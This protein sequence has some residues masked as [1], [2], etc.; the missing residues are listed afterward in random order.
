M[1]TLLLSS[2][3]SMQRRLA[4][5][6]VLLSVCAALP[7]LAQ[8]AVLEVIALKYRTAE[9]VI[10]VLRPLLDPRGSLSGMQNQLIIR[11]TPANL[12]ELKQVLA[13]LDAMP[14]R[15]LITV[16][17]DAVLDRDRTRAEVSGRV[18]A[19]D[20]TVAVPGSGR[21]GGGVVEVQRGDD[22][23][24][25]RIDST[26]SLDSDRNT[27]TLQVLE[28]NSAFI[29][30]GQSVPL[31]Q[32]QVIRTIVNGQIVERIV[33]TTE[34]RDVMTG[35]YA[36][37]RLAGDRVML[38][39]SPQHD[40]LPRPEQNLPRGSIN[41]QSAATTV[42]GRLG[43]WMEIGG[44]AQGISTQQSVTLGSTREVAADNRR[45]LLKVEEIR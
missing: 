17:Q 39:I 44:L 21:P 14:R 10:P 6:L 16:R 33:S 20:A 29:R 24:R 23:I 8:N 35:F 25:G 15:L 4:V 7:A 27:Q 9:Q 32:R 28:G 13:T 36:L 37:P 1:I 30:I 11:T 38:E 45:I 12:A 3:V 26:R 40:T 18:S 19:G 5:L 41:V 34:Y 2:W 42:S 22:V 31:P 43:E